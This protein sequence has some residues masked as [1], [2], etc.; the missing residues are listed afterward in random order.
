MD[1]KHIET[2]SMLLSD[3]CFKGLLVKPP[4]SDEMMFYKEGDKIAVT[5]GTRNIMRD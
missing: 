1:F 2:I 5:S 4:G 3:L